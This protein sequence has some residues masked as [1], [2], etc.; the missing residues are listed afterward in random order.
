MCLQ[1]NE[2]SNILLFDLAQNS[3]QDIKGEKRGEQI[4]TALKSESQAELFHS[5]YYALSSKL[6]L[7]TPRHL[8]LPLWRATWDTQQAL[9]SAATGFH[10]THQI[11]TDGQKEKITQSWRFAFSQHGQILNY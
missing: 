9:M 6:T 10:Q 5:D 8:L 7:K 2:S 4:S 11:L 3:G 1:W